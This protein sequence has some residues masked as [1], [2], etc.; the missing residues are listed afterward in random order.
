MFVLN[1]KNWIGN[2]FLIPAGPLKR[3]IKSIKNYEYFFNGNDENL[4]DF[5]K[6]KKKKIKFKNFYIQN[7]KFKNLKF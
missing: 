2:G 1:S 7:I 3:K 6:F 4:E 5:I